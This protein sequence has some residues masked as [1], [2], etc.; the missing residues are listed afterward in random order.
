MKEWNN[1]KIIAVDHGYGNIKTANTVTPTGVTVSETEPIF[2]GN[3]LKYEGRYYRIGDSRKEFVADKALDEDYYILTLMAI[4]RELNVFGIREATVHL[5]AGLPLT[6]IRRQR[7]DFRAYLLR[8]KE[9]HYRFNGKSYHIRFAGCTLYPQGYPAIVNQLSS[10]KG[11]NLLADIGNGTMNLLYIQNK[12]PM[13]NKCWTE[14]QGVNQCMIAARNAVLDKFGTKIDD[15]TIEQ[16]LRFKT[17]DIGSEYLTCIQNTARQYVADIFATL[18]RYEYNPDLM[19]LTIVGGGGCLV[20][21]YGE[22]DADRVTIIDDICAT[23]KGYEYLA[24]MSL[25]RKERA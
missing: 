16:V 11:T 19:R 20:R 17:A 13:E 10:F 2:S 8:H 5:A 12:K 3:L 15:S 22:Y 7:E 14:K 1:M 4:A 18:R 24:Y 25:R 23:A 6:W 21:N 9:V